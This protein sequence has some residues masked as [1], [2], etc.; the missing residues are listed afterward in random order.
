MRASSA[1]ARPGESRRKPVAARAPPAPG[2]ASPAAA[3]RILLL[4][5]NGVT[6]PDGA[7][8]HWDEPSA[9]LTVQHLRERI[10]TGLADGAEPWSL[11]VHPGDVSYATGLL[12]KWATFTA[13]WAGVSDVVPYFVG[14]GNHERDFPGSGNDG[15]YANSADSGGECGKVRGKSAAP[16]ARARWTAPRRLIPPPPRPISPR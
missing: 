12:L 16:G 11:V 9:S 8:D 14:Q 1:G 2:G 4:A 10:A 3:T 5:D 15:S 7:Q 13:R 6:E